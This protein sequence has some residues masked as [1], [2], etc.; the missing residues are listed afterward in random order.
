LDSMDTVAKITRRVSKENVDLTIGGGGYTRRHDGIVVQRDASQWQMSRGQKHVEK[1]MQNHSELVSETELWCF[2]KFI[3]MLMLLNCAYVAVFICTFATP[4]PKLDNGA[5]YTI[6]AFLPAVINVVFLIPAIIFSMSL[7]SAVCKVDTSVLG[8]VLERGEEVTLLLLDLQVKIS[9]RLKQRAEDNPDLVHANTLLDIFAEMDTD[10]SGAMD[11]REFMKGLHS[12][13]IFLSQAALDRLFRALDVNQNDRVD[14]QEFSK[15]MQHNDEEAT[16][17]EAQMHRHLA[18]KETPEAQK[19]YLHALM[20]SLM[21]FDV[22][23]VSRRKS[24]VD[25]PQVVEE[26]EEDD[27]QVVDF[28]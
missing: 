1:L 21:A 20:R 11:K 4:T 15:A 22:H 2:T 23:N 14:Y 10:G 26:E 13:N 16:E 18:S 8:T 24:T 3:D 28:S 5:V 12:L 6:L 7:V 27:P 17:I 9:Q 19:R 25:V